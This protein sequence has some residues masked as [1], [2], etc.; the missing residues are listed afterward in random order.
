MNVK[1]I[2]VPRRVE[3]PYALD[4]ILT[5]SRGFC[6]FSGHMDANKRFVHEEHDGVELQDERLV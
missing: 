4:L 3:V 2:L 1:A 5:F 6:F